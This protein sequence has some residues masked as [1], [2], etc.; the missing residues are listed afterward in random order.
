MADEFNKNEQTEVNGE[1]VD[2]A[3]SPAQNPTD[4]EEREMPGIKPA[5]E[6]DLDGVTIKSKP[7]VVTP[8]ITLKKSGVSAAIEDE[9]PA[10]ETVVGPAAGATKINPAGIR[11]PTGQIAMKRENTPAPPAP[12]GGGGVVPSSGADDDRPFVEKYRKALIGVIGA[13]SVLLLVGLFF[14]VKSFFTPEQE[15][16]LASSSADM[17]SVNESMSEAEDLQDLRVAAKTA[18]EVRDNNVELINQTKQKLSGDTQAQ[19]DAVLAANAK[20]YDAYAAL[21][22]ASPNQLVK[23]SRTA[24]RYRDD[25][26]D[27]ASAVES[28]DKSSTD[29]STQAQND[30]EL[31]TS[32]QENV[33]EVLANAD[34]KLQAWDRKRDRNKAALARFNTQWAAFNSI[35]NDLWDS[36]E[37]TKD[38]VHKPGTCTDSQTLPQMSSERE[39]INSRA[40]GQSAGPVLA[41]TKTR[42]VA[43]TSSSVDAMGTLQSVW[44]GWSCSSDFGGPIA[45]EPEYQS[46]YLPEN[47]SVNSK[48]AS[49]K[50]ALDAAKP[51]AQRKYRKPPRPD[52]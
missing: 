31:L 11:P 4:T 17:D 42:M 1:S 22:E 2:G 16:I 34:A 40:S 23:D 29:S 43:L 32:A 36:R 46:R 37:R 13:L 30:D 12:P 21:S 33:D 49:A 9:A 38:W 52:V 28:A 48:Q 26:D 18:K 10:A 35:Y 27:G 8:Q 19:V 6:S 3:D 5:S 41:E 45:D 20:L 24:D 47:E 7:S 39:A 15:K 44:G 25:V 14:A 51:A 50:Q